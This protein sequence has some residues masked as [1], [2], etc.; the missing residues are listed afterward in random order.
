MPDRLATGRRLVGTKQ[1]LK[2]IQAEQV[3][4]VYLARDA[5]EHVIGPVRRE[6]ETRG[7][8][9]IEVDSMAELGKACAIEVGA[10]VASVMR[11][12]EN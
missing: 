8:E 1:T 2:A 9:I 11:S 10:A 4:V 12:T 7:I 5:D 3:E 6:C